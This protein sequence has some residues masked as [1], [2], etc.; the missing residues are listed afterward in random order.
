MMTPKKI[1]FTVTNDLNYDQRMIRICSSL[2]NAGYETLLVGRVKKNSKP[3]QQQV[4]QQVRLSCFFEQGKLFYLEYNLRLFFFLLFTSCDAIC[5]I[6]LDTILPG[7]LVGKVKGK[8]IVYDAHEYFTETPEVIR[9]PIV[10]SIWEWVA[11]WCIPKVDGAYTV[12]ATLQQILSERYGLPFELIRNLPTAKDWPMASKETP[13]VLLYQGVL[14]EG[15]G[16]S[17]LLEAMQFID[18]AQLWLVGEGDLSETL[19]SQCDQLQLRD[20]VIFKGY[21]AP[22]DLPR[23]TAAATLGL[24]LLENKSLNYYYSLANKAFDY[25]QS[26]V[27]ALHMDFPEYQKLNQQ[28]PTSF[29]IKDLQPHTIASAIQQLLNDPQKYQDMVNNCQLAAKEWIW[30]R[31]GKVLLAFYEKIFLVS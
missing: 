6:D 27:P 19:R 26:G 22:A 9:R 31:E 29:L 18:N 1:I 7:V 4:F 10:K 3:L 21:I 5:S 20:R 14:N 2:A 28:Y 11:Q 8:K 25:I 13:P 15:R 23:Y 16:I 12:G 17:E 30:E 24:N